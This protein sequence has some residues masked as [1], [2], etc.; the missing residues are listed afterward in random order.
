MRPRMI[1]KKHN[2]GT[3]SESDAA[4]AYQV[5]VGFWLNESAGIWS[6]F[7]GLGAVQGIF[8]LVCSQIL[9]SDSFH[10]CCRTEVPASF[11]AKA[12][13]WLVFAVALTGVLTSVWAKKTLQ[14]AFAY[15]DYYIMRAQALE[16]AC[17]RSSFHVVNM[18]SYRLATSSFRVRDAATLTFSLF[19]LLHTILGLHALVPLLPTPP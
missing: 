5:A 12:Y 4:V 8:V 13:C 11:G 9:S 16:R 2:V 14:R 18:S 1:K 19:V 6:K 17:M 10:N 15:Q 7:A 3:R